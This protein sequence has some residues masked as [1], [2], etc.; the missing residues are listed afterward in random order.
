MSLEAPSD[1]ELTRVISSWGERRLAE[2]K[3]V[4]LHELYT[5]VAF[6]RARTVTDL[7]L[8]ERAEI[9][10]LAQPYFWPGYERV[11]PARPNERVEIHEY[12]PEWVP[13][14]HQIRDALKEKLTL[15][16]YAIE[17]IGST[18][19]P[20]LC[21][22]PTVDVM[23][24]VENSH[25]EQGY[26]EAASFAGF[27]LVTRD[28]QHRFFTTPASEP[29][30]AQLHVCDLESQFAVEHLLFRDYL[31]AHPQTRDA[32]AELKRAAA[33]EW[34]DDRIAYTYAKNSF[35]L[36]T[37]EKAHLWNRLGGDL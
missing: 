7:S 22:K 28:D 24:C 30:Y 23:L 32:Y 16:N 17:Q 29:R 12:D 18:S 2:G 26:L 31:I 1:P 36:E 9:T 33:T 6:S 19:I 20:G 27:E 25:D 8:A 34:G 37:I 14:F 4:G 13:L 10:E 3:Q 21:A 5:E 11:R 35:I 15:T